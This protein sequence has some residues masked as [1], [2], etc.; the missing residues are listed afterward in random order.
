M[1][2]FLPWYHVTIPWW[3]KFYLDIVLLYRD[4]IFYL[5]IILLYRD[6]IFYLDIMLLYRESLKQYI[7]GGYSINEFRAK[8]VR[9]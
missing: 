5:D 7:I 9:S 2:Q 3:Q 4:G 6:H 1:T 8:I